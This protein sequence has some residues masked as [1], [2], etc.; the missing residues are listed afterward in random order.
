M[1]YTAWSF[2]RKSSFPI[3]KIIGQTDEKEAELGLVSVA[4][5]LVKKAEYFK[6]IPCQEEPVFPKLEPG[7]KIS[8]SFSILFQNEEDFIEFTKSCQ[9]NG[10]V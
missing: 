4:I 9:D 2:E 3:V 10:I 1:Y 7:T 5:L 6:G 8:I